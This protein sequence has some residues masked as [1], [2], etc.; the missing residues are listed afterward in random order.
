MDWIIEIVGW[1]CIGVLWIFSEPTIRFRNWILGGH[2][3]IWRR[4]LECT[5]CSSFHIYLWTK[6]FMTGEIDILGASTCAVLA[7]VICRHLNGGSL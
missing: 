2:Q 4:L 5:M 6:L 3:G 7:E 1:A